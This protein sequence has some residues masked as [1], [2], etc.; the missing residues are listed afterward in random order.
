M[1]WSLMK[2]YPEATEDELQGYARPLAFRII[3]IVNEFIH[4]DSVFAIDIDAETRDNIVAAVADI[5][6]QYGLKSITVARSCS[7]PTVTTTG[8][9]KPKNSKKKR[10]RFLRRTSSAMQA[11]KYAPAPDCLNRLEMR[12]SQTETEENVTEFPLR[13]PHHHYVAAMPGFNSL[14]SLYTVLDEA[15][16]DVEES[17]RHD[18]FPRFCASQ[19]FAKLASDMRDQL[20]RNEELQR[21][22]LV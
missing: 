11:P 9:K 20:L 18:A 16:E 14:K 2:R 7:S 1:A 8:K 15:Q 4:E 22:D 19:A 13:L 10:R 12:I 21:V 6:R 3:Y 5:V 17:M